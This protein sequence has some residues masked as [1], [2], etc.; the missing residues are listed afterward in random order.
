VDR[1]ETESYNLKQ[2]KDQ[3][4][5][6]MSTEVD[7]PK[8]DW[9]ERYKR[10]ID[11]AWNVLFAEEDFVYRKWGKEALTEF[12]QQTRP[13]W[14]GALA[15]RLIEKAGLKPDVEG[16]IKLLGV[17]TQELWGYGDPRFAEARLETPNKGTFTN[18]VCRGWE[19]MMEHCQEINCDIACDTEYGAVVRTLSPDFRVTL[20]KARPRGDDRCEFT[21][22][23]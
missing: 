14:S 21:V 2:V 5:A 22:E 17:Y 3:K 23:L 16:A 15:K 19:K 20:T 12:I 7:I 9:F 6:G 18:L 11:F 1:L 4:E 13:Q 8:L 10:L